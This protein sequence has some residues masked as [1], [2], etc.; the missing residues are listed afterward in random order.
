MVHCNLKWNKTFKKKKIPG[1]SLWHSQ[2]RI[3]HCHCSGSGHC[4]GMGLIL[5]PGTS[6]CHGCGQK[7]KNNHFFSILFKKIIYLFCFLGP[8]PRHMKV[9]RRG[10]QSELQ[11][12]VCATATAMQDPNLVCDLYRRSQQ[13]CQWNP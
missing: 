13:C 7:G 1:V 5:G 6:A 11:L 3:W 10:V 2:L 8:H 12:P 9:P 4:C